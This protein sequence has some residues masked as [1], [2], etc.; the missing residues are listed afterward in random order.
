M[1]IKEP[2]E[3]PRLSLAERDRRHRLVREAMDRAGLDVLIL[4][5][6]VSRWEQMMADSRYITTIGG[7]GTETLTIVPRDG[8]VTAYVFNRAPFWRA[9]PGCR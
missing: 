2:Y 9:A 6:N 4:P 7:F 5:A 3:V 8:A 1:A